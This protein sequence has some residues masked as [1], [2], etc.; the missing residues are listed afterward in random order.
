MRFRGGTLS[1]RSGRQKDLHGATKLKMGKSAQYLEEETRKEKALEVEWNSADVYLKLVAAN[2]LIC[3]NGNPYF[4]HNPCS[5]CP[6]RRATSAGAVA[7]AADANYRGLTFFMQDILGGT[8][9]SAKAVTEIVNNPAAGSQVP[10]ANLNGAVLPTNNGVPVNNGNTG[11]TNNN[12]IPFLTGLSGNIPNVVLNNRKNLIVGGNGFPIVNG[13]QLPAGMTIQKLMFGTLIV[14]D[15]ELM[16]R[17]PLRS[18]MLGRAQGFH[19]VSSEDGT[20]Q[21]MAFIAMFES[22]GYIDSLCIFRVHLTS[23][24][25]RNRL[26]WAAQESM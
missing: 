14:I 3:T 21:T 8:N 12:N 13:A 23:F 18:G 20:S 5:S 4:N 17:H 24:R 10:F 9:T 1:D 16:D 19:V 7:T 6:Y 11:V 22:G 25:S 15:N 26:L 2:P